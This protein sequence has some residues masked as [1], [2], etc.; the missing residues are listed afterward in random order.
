M[1]TDCKYNSLDADKMQIIDAAIS[2]IIKLLQDDKSGK[3]IKYNYDNNPNVNKH[4]K[5]IKR[6][7]IMMKYKVRSAGLF[8]KVLI[9][10]R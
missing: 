10:S 4:H 7:L 2:N 6:R 3:Y 5:E 9:V 8:K 1:H